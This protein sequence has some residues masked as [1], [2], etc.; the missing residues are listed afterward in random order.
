VIKVWVLLAC[1]V[2]IAVVG[3]RYALPRDDTPGTTPVAVARDLNDIRNIVVPSDPAAARPWRFIIIHHSATT[4]GTVESITAGHL[5]REFDD[6]GYHFVINNG[7]S[8]GTRNGEVTA[9]GRW[10]NQRAG[11]HTKVTGHEEFNTEGIGICLVGNFEQEAPTPEQMTALT[12]LVLALREQYNIPIDRI[13]GHRDL[14]QTLCPGRHFPMDRFLLDL[15]QA[16][17]KGL[18]PPKPLA[19]RL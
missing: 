18:T 17:L 9:T 10:I 13:A 19:E 15:H 6:I 8:A 1:S 7:R 11:A 2:A 5:D 4:S 16:Y 12:M 14:K 3:C